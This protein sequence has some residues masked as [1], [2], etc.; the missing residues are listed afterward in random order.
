MH[1]YQSPPILIS[2]KCIKI[3]VFVTFSVAKASTMANSPEKDTNEALKPYTEIKDVAKEIIVIAS[4][5]NGKNGFKN[6]IMAVI[7]TVNPMLIK[8][9]LTFRFKLPGISLGAFKNI[10]TIMA[11]AN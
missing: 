5:K 8:M 6:R 2:A 7:S 11:G 9:A 10:P 3:S 1:K 4:N